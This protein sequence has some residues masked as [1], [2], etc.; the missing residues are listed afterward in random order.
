MPGSNYVDRRWGGLKAARRR[1]VGRSGTE[2]RCQPQILLTPAGAATPWPWPASSRPD[3]SATMSLGS[4]PSSIPPCNGGARS[5]L[6]IAERWHC[7]PMPPVNSKTSPRARCCA[8]STSSVSFGCL[9]ARRPRP[10]ART[11]GV[12]SSP[13]FTPPSLSSKHWRHCG[14]SIVLRAPEPGKEGQ[15]F[16]ESLEQRSLFGRAQVV[17]NPCDGRAMIE[18]SSEERGDG[19]GLRQFHREQGNRALDCHGRRRRCGRL[20]RIRAEPDDP[21]GQQQE[22]AA[23][24]LSVFSGIS[25]W[26]HNSRFK[27]QK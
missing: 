26:A 18:R 7:G 15:A 8:N 5:S 21:G 19:R 4:C 24:R 11:P 3:C 12:S 20:L 27:G 13:C 6:H 16:L 23:A 2:S 10:I 1:A 25:T 9:P 14:R 22:R 17:G